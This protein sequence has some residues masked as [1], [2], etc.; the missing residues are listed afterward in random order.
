VKSTIDATKRKA[1]FA[2]SKRLD[3]EFEQLCSQQARGG[4]IRKNP[5]TTKFLQE[6]LHRLQTTPHRYTPVSRSAVLTQ[7]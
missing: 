1:L 6:L 7:G 4:T 2:K 5:V 3:R